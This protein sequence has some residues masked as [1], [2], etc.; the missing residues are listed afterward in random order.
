M[1]VQHLPQRERLERLPGL[2][3]VRD[4]GQRGGAGG[5]RFGGPLLNGLAEPLARGAAVEKRE[6][7]LCHRSAVGQLS[8][9]VRQLE[10][11]VG[12]DQPRKDR[13]LPEVAVVGSGRD[14]PQRP[15]GVDRRPE[16]AHD[17]VADRPPGTGN[18]P[19]GRYAPCP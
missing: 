18:D 8:A 16:T 1:Q 10:V 19:I 7:P 3:V 9:K 14:L 13:H 17:A 6:Q 15:D 2:I 5:Q 11:R 4:I 12:V